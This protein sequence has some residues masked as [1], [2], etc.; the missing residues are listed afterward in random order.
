M[1]QWMRASKFF[2]GTVSTHATSKFRPELTSVVS[3]LAVL[4]LYRR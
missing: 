3:P 2:I 1:H 4:S